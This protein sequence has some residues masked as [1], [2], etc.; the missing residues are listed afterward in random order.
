MDMFRKLT[1]AE[2]TQLLK[3]VH[4]KRATVIFKFDDTA[5][6]K[7]KAAMKGWGKNILCARP[8][9]LPDTHKEGVVTCNLPL[10]GE[11]YFFQA[12]IKAS[13]KELQV[14]LENEVFQLVRRK[15]KRLR[16][17]DGVEAFFMTKRI[18]DRL[19]FLKGVLQDISDGGCRVALNVSNPIVKFNDVIVG[20]LRVGSQRSVPVAGKVRHRKTMKSGKFDQVF[21]LEFTLVEESDKAK[22]EKV[23]EAVRREIFKSSVSG[24][25]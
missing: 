24:K 14:E 20:S 6:Y 18:G 8:S 4:L 3:D 19:V 11:I 13:R 23:L 9:N 15:E 17:P 22:V 16:I 12:R 1:T 21:G 25:S 10:A 5:P 7:A 2:T